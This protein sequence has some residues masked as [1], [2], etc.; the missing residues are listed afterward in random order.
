MRS[1]IRSGGATLQMTQ[2]PNISDHSGLVPEGT[3]GLDVAFLVASNANVKSQW[4]VVSIAIHKGT[5][6]DGCVTETAGGILSF[7]PPLQ[8]GD[9]YRKPGQV[10]WT[11]AQ[12]SIPICA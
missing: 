9:F 4:K 5:D 10:G 7:F 3:R 11:P 12:E 1:C 6:W 2:N 8:N